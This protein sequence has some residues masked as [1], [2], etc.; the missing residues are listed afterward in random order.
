MQNLNRSIILE[1][2]WLQ[3]NEARMYFDLGALQIGDEYVT[4][5]EDRY[6]SSISGIAIFNSSICV[7]QTLD[8]GID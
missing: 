3:Q 6:I 8:Y 4:L 7:Q 5:E 2:D 1:W